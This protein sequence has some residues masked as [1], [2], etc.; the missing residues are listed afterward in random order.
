M[1][2][3]AAIFGARRKALLPPVSGARVLRAS[4]RQGAAM[5]TRSRRR[6]AMTAKAKR[7]RRPRKAI[8]TPIEAKRG[9]YVDYEGSKKPEPTLLG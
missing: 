5:S 6:E 1:E 3:R 2:T 8:I 9:I 7:K 4:F